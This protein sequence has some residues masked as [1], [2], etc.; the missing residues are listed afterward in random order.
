MYRHWLDTID[1]VMSE[2]KSSGKFSEGIVDAAAESITLKKTTPMYKDESSGALIEHRV[3]EMDR[4]ISWEV[5]KQRYDEAIEGGKQAFWFKS[6]Y[7][8]FGWP[9]SIDASWKAS[10]SGKL[11][12]QWQ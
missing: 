2:A 3:I 5:A 10:L 7:P 9:R 12:S 6:R 11:L 1:V 8:P 4:G